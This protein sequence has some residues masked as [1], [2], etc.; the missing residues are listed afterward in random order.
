L[1]PEEQALATVVRLLAA[2]AIPCMVTGSVA[3]SYHGRPRS[4][5]DADLVID[6]QPAQLEAL[7]RGLV[8]EGFYVDSARARDALLKRRQFNAIEM[9]SACKLD[10][11]VRQERP[12]SREEL[13][14][15]QLV[16]LGPGLV[17]PLASAE[18]TI[19]SKLEWARK[20]GGSELQLADAA[21][22]LAVNPQLDRAYLER[23]A[24]ELGILDLWLQLAG[25]PGLEEV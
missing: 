4:T 10:L 8:A 25:K 14:R 24:R 23:W 16:E 6:P 9:A 7:V 5:H 3:S 2:L 11:I 1:T 13:A 21:G 18:D 22:V 19:L 12:F 20:A 17:V 15:R